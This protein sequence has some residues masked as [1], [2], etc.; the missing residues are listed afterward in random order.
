MNF[1]VSGSGPIVNSSTPPAVT[2]RGMVERDMEEI[3]AMIDEVLTSVAAHATDLESPE[4]VA[5]VDSIRRKVH[6]MTKIYP[7]NKY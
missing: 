1:F 7:L 5:V 4:H 6:N 3:V 2:S